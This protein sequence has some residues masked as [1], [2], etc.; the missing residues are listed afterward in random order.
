MENCDREWLVYSKDLDKVFCFCC[1]LLRKGLPKGR[2]DS[3]GYR[4]WQHATTSLKEREVSLEHLKNMASWFEMHQRLKVNETIDKVAYEH[5]K[6]ECDY[7]KQVLLRIIAFVKF[8]GLVEIVEEFDLVM[9]EHV[10]RI[11]IDEI[12]VHYLGHSIQNELILLLAQQLKSEIM[13]K[14]KQAKY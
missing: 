2:L 4:D 5:F 9:K 8:L 3:K 14:I 11:T 12:H 1:K 6:K 13:K 7:W 10:C